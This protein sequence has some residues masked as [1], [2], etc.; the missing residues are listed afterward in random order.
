MYM[1]LIRVCKIKQKHTI[2]QY[3]KI[4]SENSFSFYLPSATFGKIS[5]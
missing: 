4:I 2:K 1:S 3:L 5:L